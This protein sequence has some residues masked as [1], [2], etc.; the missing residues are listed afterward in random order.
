VTDVPAQIVLAL[1]DTLT[2]GVTFGVTVIVTLFPF[3]VEE[4]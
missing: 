1:A 3:A 4:V 2:L